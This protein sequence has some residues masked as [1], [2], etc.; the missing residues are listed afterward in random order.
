MDRVKKLISDTNVIDVMTS[1]GTATTVV[2]LTNVLVLTIISPFIGYLFVF[3][4]L[5]D[6]SAFTLGNF[7]VGRLLEAAISTAIT[8]AVFFGVRSYWH[9]I[10]IVSDEQ[11]AKLN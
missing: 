4:G 5:P 2:N 11:Q 7:Q 10:S 6:L 3:L 8:L 9:R 1:T